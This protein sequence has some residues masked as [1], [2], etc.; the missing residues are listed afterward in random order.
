MNTAARKATISRT[1]FG[2]HAKDLTLGEAAFLAGLPQAPS[3][4]SPYTNP[5][6]AKRRQKEVLKSM[7]DQKL[8][9][10]DQYKK[11]IAQELEFIPLRN[12]IQAPHFVFYVKDLLEKQ[13]GIQ[14]VEEGGLKV[15]TT[16]DLD[17]QA[18]AEAIMKQEIGKLKSLRVGNGASLVTRP[19]TG[20]ILS[21]VGSYDFFA[22]GSGTFNV[23]IADR[24]PGSSIKPINYAIGIERKLVTPATIFLDSKTCFPQSFQKAY[25]PVNYDNSFHGPTALR[26]ALGNSYNIPA[27]KMLALN[28]VNDFVASA[29]A[30]LINSFKDPSQYGLSLTLG[31]GEVKMTEMAQGFSSFANEGVP[32]KLVAVL[33]IVD[34]D[35]QVI[36][37]YKDPNLKK[38]VRKKLDYPNFLV[39][40]GKPAISKETAFL[41]SHILLDNNARTAA[42]GPSSALVVP[43]QTVSVKTGTTNDKRDNWTIGYTPNFLTVVWVGN[44]DNT[45]MNPYLTSGVTGA[46]PIWNKIMRIVLENQPNMQPRKPAGVV[47]RTVCTDTGAVISSSTTPESVI[48]CPTRFEYMIQGTEGVTGGLSYGREQILINKDTGAQAVEGDANVE[49]Q[50]KTIL[51]DKFSNYCVD[52]AHPEMLT[53]TPTP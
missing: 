29:P 48:S 52:C 35:G 51:K 27:V 20:E 8:I 22:T 7:R 17:I 15:Y 32:K 38:D 14:R 11:A 37:E 1:Y 30:F 24:Q 43:N 42:F 6:G 34:K 50:E 53:P 23:T 47:G 31:G 21:M 45:P 13:Y 4:Y 44:N 10:T 26:F 41:I 39:I 19:A 12:P 16:L 28:T 25:C 49:M 2:K 3:A 9:T 46:A 18:S 33:K 36:Y 5:E 40:D